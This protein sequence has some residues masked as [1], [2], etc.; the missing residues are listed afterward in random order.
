M[1][2][3]VGQSGPTRDPTP[4]HHVGLT[5][6]YADRMSLFVCA[7]CN[8]VE[9]TATAEGGYYR[10]HMDEG[11]PPRCSQCQ[12]GR[13]HGHFDRVDATAYPNPAGLDLTPAN[14]WRYTRTTR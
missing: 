3:Q 6:V 7:E 8:V 12:T 14:G 4:H 11:H 5:T 13:W 10:H 9:N 2:G 1:A